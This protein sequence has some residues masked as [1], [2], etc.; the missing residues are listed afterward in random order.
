MSCASSANHVS[1]TG[2]PRIGAIIRG[3]PTGRGKEYSP[4]WYSFRKHQYARYLPSWEKAG[5]PS[6]THIGPIGMCLLSI[7]SV[8]RR[9]IFVCSSSGATSAKAIHF[10]SGDQLIRVKFLRGEKTFQGIRVERNFLS[11]PP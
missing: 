2:N 4:A 1:P 3:F 7:V 5:K 9:E 11:G 6:L 8:E 10:P